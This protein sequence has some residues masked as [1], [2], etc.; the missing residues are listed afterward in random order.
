MPSLRAMGDIR[1]CNDMPSAH[2]RPHR[3]VLGRKGLCFH[4]QPKVSS[5]RNHRLNHSHGRVTNK[6]ISH[7]SEVDLR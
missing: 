1:D 3:T 2:E 4:R 7:C 6:C 5:K